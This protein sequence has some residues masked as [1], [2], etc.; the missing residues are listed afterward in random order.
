MMNERLKTYDLT[1][2]SIKQTVLLSSVADSLDKFILTYK[3]PTKDIFTFEG[4]WKEDSVFIQMRKIDI[5]QF[6]LVRWKSRW[7]YRGG[8]TNY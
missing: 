7:I 1:A 4:K 5:D 8:A 6:R 2:D 3:Q